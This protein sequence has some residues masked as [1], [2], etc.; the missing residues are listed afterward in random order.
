M[1]VCICHIDTFMYECACHTHVHTHAHTYV[2][3]YIHV[4][5][6]SHTHMWVCVHVLEAQE[7]NILNILSRVELCN[8]V[9]KFGRCTFAVFVFG[10]LLHF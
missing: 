9:T 4:H 10:N 5:T 7:E 1:Y 2:Y 6:S 8:S 3:T